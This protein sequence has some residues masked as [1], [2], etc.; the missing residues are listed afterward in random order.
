MLQARRRENTQRTPVL[1]YIYSL[2]IYSPLWLPQVR[3]LSHDSFFSLSCLVFRGAKEKGGAGSNKFLHKL[4][5]RLTKLT[6]VGLRAPVLEHLRLIE[7][8]G[9]QRLDGGV[10]VVG[11]VKENR[12]RPGGRGV[13]AVRGVRQGGMVSL[14][15]CRLS[16]REKTAFNLMPAVSSC[17]Q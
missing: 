3:Y 15:P 14:Q 9:G 13:A 10:G 8:A 12:R 4:R 16:G 7:L 17:N 6:F 2:F 11:V 1:H 5:R